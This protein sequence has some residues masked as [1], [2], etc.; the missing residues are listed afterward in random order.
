MSA[1]T[2]T[3]AQTVVATRMSNPFA[4]RWVRP[5]AVPYIFSPE[6]NAKLLIEKLR[7]A[8]WRGAIVGPHGSGKSTLLA[9]LL[10][11]IECMGICVRWI[12]LHN[13]QRNLP[14]GVLTLPLLQK[15]SETG[16]RESER[17]AA[18]IVVDG[19][20]QLSWW[21]RRRLATACRRSG[22]GLLVTMHREPRRNKF[23]A[24][25]FSKFFDFPVLFRTAA[26]LPTLRHMVERVLPPHGGYIHHEDVATAFHSQQGNVREAL[27]ALYDLFEQRRHISN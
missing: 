19:Y 10:P 9:T 20:E 23:P 8:N 18:L 14:Q 2:Q 13:G 3:Q 17:S 21:A 6:A 5:G 12:T 27:F 4:T 22:W 15:S 25:F 24:I 16:P 11:L 7:R 26:D 1:E